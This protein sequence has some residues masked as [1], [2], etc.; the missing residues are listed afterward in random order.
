MLPGEP[1][2][3]DALLALEAEHTRAGRSPLAVILPRKLLHEVTVEWRALNVSLLEE[4]PGAQLVVEE[5][6]SNAVLA[7]WITYATASGRT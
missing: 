6:S 4:Q 7:S 2:S 3:M 1:T 5:R